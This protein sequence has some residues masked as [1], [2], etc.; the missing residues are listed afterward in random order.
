MAS[1]WAGAHAADMSLLRRALLA[2]AVFSTATGALALLSPDAVGAW[3][4]LDAPAVLQTTGA[5]L[6]VFAALVAFVARRSRPQPL[7]VLLI[8]AADL[9]WVVGTVVLLVGWSGLFS[10]SGIALLVGVAAIVDTFAV[11]QL[12]GLAKQ[13]RHPEP[14]SAHTHRLCLQTT[15]DAPP[16]AMW[17][18]VSDLPGIARHSPS[19]REST[20]IAGDAPGPDAARMCIDTRDRRWTERVIDWQQGR[21]FTLRFDADAPGFPF[22]FREMVGGWR[23]ESA[24]RGTE[25]SVWWDVTPRARR[26]GGLVVAMMAAMAAPSMRRLIASMAAEARGEAPGPRKRRR[27]RPA[28]AC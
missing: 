26:F 22:P 15:V 7:P 16:A 6:L 8:S 14:G 1:A 21:A 5:Q 23:I 17:S 18:V 9:L 13:Y 24:D 12:A 3:I 10:A 25:V 11:L 19:L 27:P 20:L 2:N 4:G 28:I